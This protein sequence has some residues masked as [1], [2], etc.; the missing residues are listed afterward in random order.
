MRGNLGGDIVIIIIIIIIII[1]VLGVA[2]KA[3]ENGTRRV[4]K[5]GLNRG[6]VKQGQGTA[7]VTDA[8]RPCA[9]TGHTSIILAMSKRF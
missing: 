9:D 3:F 4:R 8:F 2:K 5:G 1:P 6:L 7:I